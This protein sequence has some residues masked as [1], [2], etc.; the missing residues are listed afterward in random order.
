M[1]SGFITYQKFDDIALANEL[2]EVLQKHDIKYLLDEVSQTFDPT[3]SFNPLAKEYDVKINS[4]DFERVTQIL[5]K[6]ESKNTNSVDKDYYLFSFTNDE[7]LEVITKADEWNP[8]DVVLARKILSERGENLTDTAI[9]AINEKR[10]QEL[11][12][13]DPPQTYW[14]VIGYICAFGGGILGLF[15]GW[16]LTTYKKTLPNGERVYQYTERDRKHGR[17]IFYISVICFC[18]AL[19]YKFGIIFPES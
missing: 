7:L 8:F 19:L 3:F 9:E 6:E 12:I 18:V 1:E 14:I 13:P 15:I 2:M 4:S 16:Y 5:K 10:I 17:I 11:K